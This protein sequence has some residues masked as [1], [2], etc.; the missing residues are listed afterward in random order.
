MID[1]S[2]EFVVRALNQSLV[3]SFDLESDVVVINNLV[4]P[5]GSTPQKNQNRL[6]ITLVNL[7][8]ETNKRYYGGQQWESSMV[9][10]VNPAVFF[11]LDVLVSANF[12]DYA[13]SLK[14]LTA[15]IGFFQENLVISRAS[16]P[17]LPD[18][19][20]LLKFEIENTPS[21]KTHNLWTAL[22]AKYVPSIVYKI[23]HVAVDAR[24]IKGGSTMVQDTST[25]VVQ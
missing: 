8:Y 25:A 9:N 2:L 12:D 15:A 20:A 11:N 24:Q 16:S 1:V 23:R 14:F 3:T 10:R 18:G 6:V 19:V 21:T 22:G 13:E 7:E 17:N 4:D 5:N